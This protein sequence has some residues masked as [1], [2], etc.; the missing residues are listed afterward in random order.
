MSGPQGT[1]RS[2]PP[3]PND[4]STNKDFLVARFQL[5][6]AAGIQSEGVGSREG[7]SDVPCGRRG[8]GGKGMTGDCEILSLSLTLR[9]RL[10]IDSVDFSERG[11]C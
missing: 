3:P 4:N 8:D 2:A 10:L 11:G 6:D 5:N 1:T 9:A 7:V